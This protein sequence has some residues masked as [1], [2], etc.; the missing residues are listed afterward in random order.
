[1]APSAPRSSR[2]WVA[3]GV[4][5]VALVAALLVLRMFD[6]DADGPVDGPDAPTLEQPDGKSMKLE[7]N[8]PTRDRSA[9]PIPGVAER[10]TALEK[11]REEAVEEPVLVYGKVVDGA[12]KALPDIDVTLYDDLGDY[13]DTTTSD[14]DGEFSFA[15]DEPLGAG[16]SV[17]TD[18]DPMAD[19][20]QA[21][22]TVPAIHVHDA[23][24]VPGDV[25]VRVELVVARAPRIEGI[26]L[27]ALSG[28]PIEM[29]DVEVVVTAAGFVDE[30]QDGFTDEDGTFSMSIV[31]IP[32]QGLLV[33]VTDDEGRTS[34]QGPFDLR[35]G[36]SKYL[37]FRIGDSLELTGT[38]HDASSGLPL[39][40]VEVYLL[41]VHPT[42]DDGDAWDVTADDGSFSLEDVP[43][44]AD[45]LWLFTYAE[46]NGPALVPV[47]DPRRP[48][49]VRLGGY[50][51]VKGVVTS[52]GEEGEPVPDAELRFV[53]RGP[54]TVLEDWEDTAYSDDDGE[55]ELE[56]E[57][58]PPEAAEVFVEAPGY[59]RARMHLS[60]IAPTGK[61]WR[62]YTVAITL[63]PSGG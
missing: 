58:V 20:D 9:T 4:A 18:P 2:P 29:A 21:S 17:A 56:L 25:P 27:D 30:Y 54:Y 46:E 3:L 57:S 19:P 51:T 55:F 10:D 22:S 47:T 41:P 63:E 43:S 42:F 34:V 5:V 26:A 38:V 49:D 28:E 1:M 8:T 62:E 37:E 23:A 15:W 45:R 6:E 16:W 61:G 36:E 59:V 14:D 52:T 40:G 7:P 35:P 48:V 39:E 12:G 44:G 13:L 31:D 50:V 32:A 11:A 60:D 33:R 24:V 53:L